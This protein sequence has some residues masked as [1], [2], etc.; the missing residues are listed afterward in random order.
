V[1]D[2]L[3]ATQGNFGLL[4][5]VPIGELTYLDDFTFE[6]D[7]ALKPVIPG[8]ELGD[9][10]V[11]R[12]SP[13]P[14]FASM[15]IHDGSRVGLTVDNPRGTY[16]SEAGLPE[17]FPEIYVVPAYALDE[18]DRLLCGTSLG[19]TQVIF[20]EGAVLTI[21]K[22]P[23]VTDGTFDAGEALPLKGHPGCVGRQA[24]T[25]F[26]VSGEARAAWVSP[27]GV[28]TTNGATCEPLSLD[29]DW[30]NEVNVAF[31]STAVLKWDAKWLRLI[32]EF[33]SDGDGANDREAFCHM[34]HTNDRG[35][36][37]WSQP[38]PKRVSAIASGLIDRQYR[39]YSG[40]P[41]DGAVYL[42]E[43]G[44][45]DAA[46][47][48]PVAMDIET[49]ESGSGRTD[50]AC[51]VARLL[52]S[53]WGAGA[54]GTVTVTAIYPEGESDAISE[55]VSLKGRGGS[56]AMVARAAEKFTYRFQ[57]SG[58]AT[59]AILGLEPEM[60]RQGRSGSAQRWQTVSAT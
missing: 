14:S 19:R 51:T 36:P 29:L 27:F 47:G 53:V 5:T 12:D 15:W 43:S 54:E 7:F 46:T 37:K 10:M 9:I 48:S 49:G 23:R 11:P 21:D 22:F 35:Q 13:P 25:P 39:R 41:I 57:H 59:G 6:A 34:A 44:G 1:P 16:Y 33:D 2:G 60:E 24:M 56:D 3:V 45:I 26:S 58:E 20:A 4:A 40:H 17:S 42:E 18:H 52:H 32:F 55:V 30:E 8:K 38:T 50:E 28:Y 31:L